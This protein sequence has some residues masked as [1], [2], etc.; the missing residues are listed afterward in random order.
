VP[1]QWWGNRQGGI[2]GAIFG[3]VVGTLGGL[4]GW[5]GGRGK[6][7]GFVLGAMKLIPL[8]GLACLAAGVVAVIDAQPYAVYYP[9]LLA[10]V[11]C[12]VVPFASLRRV[13]QRYE[14][15]ELRRM[16]ALDA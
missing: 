3:V 10:G 4:I 8:L 15:L 7:R 16:E 13:R 2:L 11:I 5:L 9:L 14:E 1:G 12:A 6:A